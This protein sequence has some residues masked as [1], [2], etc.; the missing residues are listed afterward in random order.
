ML[1]V[2]A[3]VAA[4][5]ALTAGAS[6]KSKPKPPSIPSCSHFSD[7]ALAKVLGLVKLKYKGKTPHSNICTWE[8]T[9]S[10]HYHQILQID[11]IPGIKSVYELAQTTGQKTAAKD[12]K[13]FGTLGSR[14]YP[15]KAG[16]FVTGTTSDSGL[17]P[18]EPGHKLPDFGPPMC[19]GDPEWTTINVTAYSSKM[20]VAAGIGVQ[21]GDAHLSGMVELV[22]EIVSGKLH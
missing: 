8:G 1:A 2:L 5:L 15:W 17:K 13:Q 16:F 11:V 22:K 12:H 9:K 4:I 21:L 10:G 19:A 6:A 3:L 20:M 18:C 14:G 7:N